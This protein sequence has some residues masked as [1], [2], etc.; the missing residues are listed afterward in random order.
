MLKRNILTCVIF[1]VAITATF[2]I[3]MPESLR[4]M[5]AAD[6]FVWDKDFFLGKLSEAPGFSSWLNNCL[7]Q[8]FGI[9]LV[10]M[11]IE[12][13]ILTLCGLM[14][15]LL[16]WALGR[17]GYSEWGILF[18]LVLMIVIPFNME[19]Y[20]EAL[21]FFTALVA[22]FRIH[23]QWVTAAG[24]I[25]LAVVGFFLMSTTLLM[26]A[27]VLIAVAYMLRRRSIAVGVAAAVALAVVVGMVKW[28][29][30]HLG[31]IPFNQRYFYA[32]VRIGNV[33]LYLLLYVCIIALMLLPRKEGG[34][35]LGRLAFTLSLAAI[36]A[37]AA[38]GVSNQ[39]MRFT[40]RFY[41]LQNL[42]ENK[43]WRELLD[44]IP[45]GEMQEN[46]MNLCYSLLAESATGTLTNN[47]F[48]Y[49]I[50]N[51][52][53]YLFRHETKKYSC[54][55]NRLFYDNLGL[56][57]EA[58]RMAFEYAV[59]MPEGMCFGSMRQMIHYAILTGDWKVAEKYLEILDH[60]SCNKGF[61]EQE[62]QLMANSKPLPQRDIM[63]DTYVNLY[64][65]NSEMIRQ[66]DY[67]P[68]NQKALDYLLL[69]LLLQKEVQKFAIIIEGIEYYQGKQ[70]PRAYAEAMA[71]LSS[72]PNYKYLHDKFKYSNELDKQF[73]EFLKKKQ[74]G[75]TAQQMASY[76]GSYW[77]YFFY[78]QQHTGPT[79]PAAASK[80]V[81]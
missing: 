8:Y 22:G 16:P 55:F 10:G 59:M 58:F 61:V 68:N 78:I 69:G 62:R 6:F 80:I 79:P 33:W 49:P 56:Y 67:N 29:N 38:Y 73:L 26:L 60:T 47:I 3:V 75:A 54:M 74:A 34:K 77:F 13:L 65:I 4:Q 11:M 45:Y 20:L 44:K 39:N 18:P 63:R 31:F 72:D 21:F 41:K 36:A 51:P 66:L 19:V 71:M 7:Q 57:D 9:P 42:A 1:F 52:E 76:M 5:E 35:W 24:L 81:N 53:D 50:M 14:C 64:P 15:G 2:T 30:T 25:V 70:L 37:G 12:A 32:P 27:I 17:K 23:H 40:E 43:E 28:S 48:Y 46:K